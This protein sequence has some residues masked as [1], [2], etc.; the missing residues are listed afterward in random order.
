[1]NEDI[2]A[3]KDQNKTTIYSLECATSFQQRFYSDFKSAFLNGRYLDV[4]DNV[5]YL[6]ILMSDFENDFKHD[7]N[8][9]IFSNRLNILANQYPMMNYYK[10]STLISAL[11]Y[12]IVGDNWKHLPILENLC[13][14]IKTEMGEASITS[15]PINWILELLKCSTICDR[16]IYVFY[17]Q[18]TRILRR[19]GFGIVPNSEIEHKKL[20]YGDT[21]V[22]YKFENAKNYLVIEREYHKLRK[23]AEKEGYRLIDV[24]FRLATKIILEDE[25]LPN[26]LGSIDYFIN[27]LTSY[28]DQKGIPQTV[29]SHLKSLVRW[30]LV[31]KKCILDKTM[32]KF[33]M[34]KLSS[35][36]RE[37]MA[38]ALLRITCNSGDFRP[39]RVECLKRILPLFGMESENVHSQIHRLLTDRDGFAVIEKKSDSIEFTINENSKYPQNNPATNVIID[40]NKLQILEQQTKI[41]QELLFDIFKEEELAPLNY[42]VSNG[43]TNTWMA[44]LKTLLLKDIWNRGEVESICRERGLMPAAVLEQI[45]DYAYEKVNDTIIDEDGDRIYVSLEYKEE[46]I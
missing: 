2:P 3:W 46:L 16:D 35:E 9:E 42:T 21:C 43:T 29:R 5:N 20:T 27:Q 40:P 7:H 22:L 11:L 28:I 26:D 44:V 15:K 13:S 19:L 32:K 38:H 41:S 4:K 33:I 14:H 12:V 39:K 24:F 6:R 1:M 25:L 36:Q 31:S 45:N 23:F 10:N 18:L 34:E 30:R 17:G 37:L 8:Y